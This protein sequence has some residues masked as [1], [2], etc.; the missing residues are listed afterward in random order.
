MLV[1][2]YIFIGVIVSKK[3]YSYSYLLLLL[4]FYK[5]L[6]SFIDWME[7]GHFSWVAESQDYPATQDQLS[8]WANSV[9]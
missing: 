4:L 2:V 3:N 8:N 5:T 7:D 9:Q 1:V 6:K